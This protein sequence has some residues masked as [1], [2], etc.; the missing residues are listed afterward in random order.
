M[1]RQ[2]FRK[3]EELV[4]NRTRPELLDIY[5]GFVD[6]V[7]SLYGKLC[8]TAEDVYNIDETLLR[9]T[10][11]L[12]AIQTLQA[13]E[14]EVGS[15]TDARIQCDGSFVAAINGAGNCLLVGV[16]LKIFDQHKKGSP[17]KEE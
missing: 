14:Q 12:C 6:S 15:N 13:A 11:F 17:T 1:P 3:R 8:L 10:K 4:A 5:L 16:I 7:E 9:A 2:H